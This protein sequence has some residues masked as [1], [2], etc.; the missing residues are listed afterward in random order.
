[1]AGHR[2][3]ITAAAVAIVAGFLAAVAAFAFG[4]GGGT[5]APAHPPTASQV[6]A[7]IGATG[8]SDEGSQG[9]AQV[10]DSGVASEN[11]R[12]VRVYT[13]AGS[14]QRDA[15][16][17]VAEHFGVVPLRQGDTWVAYYG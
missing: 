9:N 3:W 5:Q 13:F 14:A 8:F 7:L 15:W 2:N 1:M 10:T 17:A 16:L 11:G 12:Q 6:A 4:G